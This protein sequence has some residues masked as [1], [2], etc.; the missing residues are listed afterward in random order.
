MNSKQRVKAALDFQKTDKI[1]YGE[2]AI[3]SPIIEKVLGRPCYLRNKAKI[4]IALWENRRDEVAECL[5]KEIID[6]FSKIEILDVINLA[7]DATCILPP[8]GIKIKSPKK[9]DDNTWI[10][11]IGKVYKYSDLTRDIIIVK[12]P[13]IQKTLKDYEKEV[14]FNI[15]DES[16]FEVLDFVIGKFGDDKFLIGP[17]GPEVAVI[18]L[19]GD[20]ERG[21]GGG[22]IGEALMEYYINPGIIK[23]IADLQVASANK[24]DNYYIRKGI[25]GIHWGQDFADNSGPMISPQM[26]EEFVVPYSIKRMENIKKHFGLPVIKHACGNN[27]KLLNMFI[28]IGYDCY[29]SI[30]ESAG[31][32]FGRLKKE[33]G[34]KICLWGGIPSEYLY[35]EDSNSKKTI[36]ESV[37]KALE[38]GSPGGGFILGTSHSVATGSKYDNFMEMLDAINKLRDLY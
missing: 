20:I 31:M 12:Y 33:Y 38:T 16:V 21:I 37:K 26:F 28:K 19:K 15:P 4:Q 35:T 30:Q 36:Y 24:L 1:P 7:A 13:D 2:Y 9:I 10:D 14:E 6:F 17:S 3:D 32:E 27:W 18:N 23:R 11:D 8:K 34:E 25:D 5:K 29:Q 22:N